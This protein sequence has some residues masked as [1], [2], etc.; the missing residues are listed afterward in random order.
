M[1][2]C[3]G[4]A[5]VPRAGERILAMSVFSDKGAHLI[6]SLGR[7]PRI[8][9]AQTSALK[10]RFTAEQVQKLDELCFQRVLR[11]INFLGRCPRLK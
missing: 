9:E 1:R 11:A 8:H 2:V 3:L 7:R 4:G 10:A 6:S 5:C